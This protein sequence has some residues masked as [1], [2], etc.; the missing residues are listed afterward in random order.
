MTDASEVRMHVLPADPRAHAFL[1]GQPHVE[2]GNQ[3]RP[4]DLHERHRHEPEIVARCQS[5]VL[6]LQVTGKRDSPDPEMMKRHGCGG[7]MSVCRI[8]RD[9][10][11]TRI[12]AS[13]DRRE[14]GRHPYDEDR[15]DGIVDRNAT[16]KVLDK[17]KSVSL[18][19]IV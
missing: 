18:N 7:P 4:E 13:G 17:V 9:G 12:D 3:E 5:G 15:S 11:I 6:R 19:N 16:S 14:Q 2:R 8:A 1:H 10:R